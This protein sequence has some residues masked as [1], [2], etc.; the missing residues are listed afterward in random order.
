MHVEKM[1]EKNVCTKQKT[2]KK[3]SAQK[4]QPKK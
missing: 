2:V 1:R 3:N 4:N